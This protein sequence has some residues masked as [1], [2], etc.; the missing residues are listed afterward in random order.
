MES[1]CHCSGDSKYVL[2]GGEDDLVS[3][4]SL[5]QQA[6]VAWGEGHTSYVSPSPYH[7][8]SVQSSVLRIVYDVLHLRALLLIEEIVPQSKEFYPRRRD[9]LLSCESHVW[10]RRGRSFNS[11]GPA[12]QVC[13]AS[14]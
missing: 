13:R 5:E 10:V 2:T 12:R 11:S 7:A 3:L 14:G 6:V 8:D 1:L 4:F 9:A